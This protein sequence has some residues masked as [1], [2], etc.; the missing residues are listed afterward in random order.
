MTSIPHAVCFLL[1]MFS[2]VGSKVGLNEFLTKAT[3]AK[4]T[5]RQVRMSW[6]VLHCCTWKV[7]FFNLKLQI[8]KES[9]GG[10]GGQKG[11]VS[12]AFH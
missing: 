1:L 3:H 9:E 10:G 8:S 7:G 6:D 5:H 12:L 11:S 4:E 2:G